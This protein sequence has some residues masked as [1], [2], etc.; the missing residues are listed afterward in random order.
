MRSRA[1]KID[2]II[3][4][5]RPVV[6]EHVSDFIYRNGARQDFLDDLLLTSQAAANKI[7]GSPIRVCEV[8]GTAIEDNSISYNING[9]GLQLEIPDT[10]RIALWMQKKEGSQEVWEALWRGTEEG[11]EGVVPALFQWA[12]PVYE[13][14]CAGLLQGPPFDGQD[15]P[16][17][18]VQGSSLFA[19]YGEIFITIT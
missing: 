8:I 10:F 19:H 3:A 15:Y 16:L 17:Q 5:L 14:G 6:A 11:S 18:V 2:A 9:T 1:E 7:M 13:D 12:G 4:F